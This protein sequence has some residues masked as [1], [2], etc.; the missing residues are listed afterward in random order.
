[1]QNSSDLGHYE[2]KFPIWAPIVMLF[3][4]FFPSVP[5][6]NFLWE[7]DLTSIFCDRRTHVRGFSHSMAAN[8]ITVLQ[9]SPLIWHLGMK[10]DALSADLGI[11]I[12]NFHAFWIWMM[13][14]GTESTNGCSWMNGPKN[15]SLTNNNRVL[16]GWWS[17][18]CSNSVARSSWPGTSTKCAKNSFYEVFHT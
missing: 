11:N 15:F 12:H 17:T 6:P 3:P 10:G 18:S 7:S 13:Q 1:M 14:F 2:M 5:S 4:W 16:R 9:A 8:R